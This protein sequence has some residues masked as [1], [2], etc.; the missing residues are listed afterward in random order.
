MGDCN[1]ATNRKSE[2]VNEG[3]WLK[4]CPPR[5]DETIRI[6]NEYGIGFKEESKARFFAH[7]VKVYDKLNFPYEDY[8]FDPSRTQS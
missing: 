8:Y 1:Y 7:K 6:F 5:I 3:I 2:G 4:G